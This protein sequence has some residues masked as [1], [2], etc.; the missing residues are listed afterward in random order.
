M[1]KEIEMLRVFYFVY[2]TTKN[3]NIE[4]ELILFDFGKFTEAFWH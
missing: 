1:I 4:W 2:S 3:S